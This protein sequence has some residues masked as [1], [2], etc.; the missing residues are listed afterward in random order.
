[1]K[2]ILQNTKKSVITLIKFKCNHTTL[3]KPS[4]YTNYTITLPKTSQKIP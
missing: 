4:N 2:A 1:M 3:D